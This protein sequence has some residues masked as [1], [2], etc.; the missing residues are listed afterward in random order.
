MQFLFCPDSKMTVTTFSYRDLQLAL[1]VI[2]MTMLELKLTTTKFVQAETSDT[3][4]CLIKRAFLN[5]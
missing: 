4:G 1:I 3:I 2:R 5:T